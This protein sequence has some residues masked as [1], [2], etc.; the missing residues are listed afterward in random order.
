LRSSSSLMAAAAIFCA[1]GSSAYSIAGIFGVSPA[2]KG[3]VSNVV[4]GV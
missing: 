1:L 4:K 2:G 3:K